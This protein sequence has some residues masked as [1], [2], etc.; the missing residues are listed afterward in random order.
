MPNHIPGN[1]IYAN[2]LRFDSLILQFI[3]ILNKT[4]K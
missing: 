2:K 1:Q 4:G 3:L